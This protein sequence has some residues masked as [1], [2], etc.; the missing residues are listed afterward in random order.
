MNDE[1][2]RI[3]TAPAW[4]DY[5]KPGDAAVMVTGVPAEIREVFFRS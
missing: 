1:L 5:V 4:R 2:E 3:W